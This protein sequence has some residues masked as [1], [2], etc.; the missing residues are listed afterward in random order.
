MALLSL[1]DK[2][3]LQANSTGL[4]GLS[5]DGVVFAVIDSFIFFVCFSH[6]LHLNSLSGRYALL[7]C[8]MSQ[9]EGAGGWGGCCWSVGC[10]V[11]VGG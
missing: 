8:V 4:F 7:I 6:S 11:V 2:T 5:V 9:V 1:V 10:R 3:R